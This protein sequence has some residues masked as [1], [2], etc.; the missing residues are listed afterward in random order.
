MST[1]PMR[2]DRRNDGQSPLGVCPV[3]TDDLP[4]DGAVFI[5]HQNAANALSDFVAVM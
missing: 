1:I 4:G 2:D 5:A 3:C